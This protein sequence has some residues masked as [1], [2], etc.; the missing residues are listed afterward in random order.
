M[1]IKRFYAEAECNSCGHEQ[2]HYIKMPEDYSD[3]DLRE[4][5]DDQAQQVR[6]MR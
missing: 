3:S 1:T 5:L 2:G 4:A 6:R